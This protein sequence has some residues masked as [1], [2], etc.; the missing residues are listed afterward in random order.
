MQL[1]DYFDFTEPDVIRIKGHRLGLEDVIELYQAGYSAEQISLEFPGLSLEQI[2]AAITY[3]WHN[4]ADVDAY[5][6]RLN[7]MAQES[8]RLQQKQP[9]SPV[10]QRIRA[11]QNKPDLPQ[12]AL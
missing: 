3:Y 7:K 5:L 12:P 2:H 10:A 1:E 9:L 6:N 8:I 4:Q 11:L